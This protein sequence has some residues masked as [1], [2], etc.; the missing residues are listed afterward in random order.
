MNLNRLNSMNFSCR[1]TLC[2]ENTPDINNPAL[3]RLV[4]RIFHLFKKDI[5]VQEITKIS[6]DCVTFR[7]VKP[8]FRDEAFHE[9]IIYGRGVVCP[10]LHK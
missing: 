10:A 1:V 5:E 4:R 9:W 3:A 8:G 6:L 7:T 2:L